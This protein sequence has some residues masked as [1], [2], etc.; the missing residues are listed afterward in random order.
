[1]FEAQEEN[2]FLQHVLTRFLVCV[3]M[4]ASLLIVSEQILFSLVLMLGFSRGW[5]RLHPINCGQCYGGYQSQTK[6]EIILR[7][8]NSHPKKII[9]ETQK[10][11]Q[12][13]LMQ[14]KL[15]CAHSIENLSSLYIFLKSSVVCCHQAFKLLLQV[16]RVSLPVLLCKRLSASSQS[17]QPRLCHSSIGID[18][19]TTWRSN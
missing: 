1:M 11:G 2:W 6:Y 4:S 7:S 13:W 8:E 3:D 19:Y 16:A 10:K 9:P 17:W 15:D 18:T 12:H 5:F 14:V